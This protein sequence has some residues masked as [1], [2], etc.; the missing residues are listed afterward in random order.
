VFGFGHAV[1]RAEDPRAK[2]FYELAAKL[3]PENPRVKIAQLLRSEGQKVLKENPKISD[4]YPNVDA[5]SGTVLAA[6]GFDYPQYFTVL[7]GVS[8]I[9]GIA[10][11]IVYER[12]YARDGKGTPIVRPKY[13]SKPRVVS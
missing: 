1:L 4:P 6:A 7:F 11:Q 9:V 13:I 2:V 12:V 5:I 10:F 8:R 3:F